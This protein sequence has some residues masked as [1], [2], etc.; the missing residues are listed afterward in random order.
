MCIEAGRASLAKSKR[1]GKEGRMGAGGGGLGL[2][3]RQ[4]TQGRYI[5]Y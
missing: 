3:H 5:E 4:E 1:N 2:S